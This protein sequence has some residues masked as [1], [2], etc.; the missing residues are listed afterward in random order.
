MALFNQ[1][2]KKVKMSSWD[3]VKFQIM[4]YCYLEKVIVSESDLECLTFLAIQG[5]QELTGFCN[6]CAARK[7]FSSPQTVRNAITKAE[8]KGL[9]RKTLSKTKKKIVVNPDMKVTTEG[10]IMLDFKFAAIAETQ[11]A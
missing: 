11:E 8:K 5:E 10:N 6:D 4:T 9:I 3:I 1:V 2:V 7:I